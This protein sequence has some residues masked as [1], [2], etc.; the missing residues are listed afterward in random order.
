MKTNGK[1]GLQMIEKLDKIDLR[2]IRLLQNDGRMASSEIAKTIAQRSWQE[3]TGLLRKVSMLASA[4]TI[5]V[6][7][8]LTL[9]GTWVI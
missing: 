5:V 9:F 1:K 8:G 7:G 6:A 4:W 3:T 2:I